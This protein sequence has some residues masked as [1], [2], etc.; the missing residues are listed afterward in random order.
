VVS[1]LVGSSPVTMAALML[2][3][4]LLAAGSFLLLARGAESQPATR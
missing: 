2:L 4:A 3:A 1:P